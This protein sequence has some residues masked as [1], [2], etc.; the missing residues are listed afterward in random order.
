MSPRDIE[1]QT[2]DIISCFFEEEQKPVC[3]RT[4]DG[5]I[6][7]DGPGDG[8]NFTMR[9]VISSGILCLFN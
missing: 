4:G 5:G 8:N 6:E 3:H 1:Q 7:S 2:F 9:T